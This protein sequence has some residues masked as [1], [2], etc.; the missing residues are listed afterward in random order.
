MSD[1]A[2]PYPVEINVQWGEMDALGHVNNTV[3]IR[4]F[5]TSRVHM[6]MQAGLW[7]IYSKMGI[8]I[9]LAKI[10]CNFIRP[11]YFP[12]TVIAQT[13]FKS[14]GRSSIVV[15]HQ[16]FSKQQNAVAATGDGVIVF[17]DAT[18]MKSTPIPDVI[19]TQIE[20]LMAAEVKGE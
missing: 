17:T 12:D 5:E 15:E 11:L 16:I 6:M 13:R 18:T 4:Y 7:D 19:R 20:A 14:I 9:V 3:F 2:F 1:Q 8:M 10:E